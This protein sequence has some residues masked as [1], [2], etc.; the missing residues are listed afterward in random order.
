MDRLRSNLVLTKDKIF[1]VEK[2]HL[3]EADRMTGEKEVVDYVGC[4]DATLA[5]S[6]DRLMLSEKSSHGDSVSL[7]ESLH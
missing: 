2:K 1:F 7:N 4:A 5:V 6:E 3:F